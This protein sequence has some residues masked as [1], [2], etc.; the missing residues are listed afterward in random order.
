MTTIS[1]ASPPPPQTDSCLK[2]RGVIDIDHEF[3]AARI[4]LVDTCNHK[5]ISTHFA[6]RK[7]TRITAVDAR[8]TISKE[9]MSSALRLI[10]HYNQVSRVSH[11]NHNI[12]VIVRGP[13]TKSPNVLS[14]LHKIRTAI[15][16]SPKLIKESEFGKIY[17]HAAATQTSFKMEEI[18]L[19][20]IS[21]DEMWFSYL[22]GDEAIMLKKD[23][24]AL[25]L[26]KEA[27]RIL[28]RESTPNPMNEK[29]ITQVYD[30]AKEIIGDWM[31]SPDLSKLKFEHR[32]VVGLGDIH[33][34]SIK[35]QTA[36][37]VSYNE[38]QI[39]TALKGRTGLPDQAISGDAPQM[40]VTNLIF[41]L[42]TMKG[43]GISEVELDQVGF[44]FGLLT[45]RS[46]WV[47]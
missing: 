43:L 11:K 23:F 7:P 28:G 24:G 20:S 35:S 30:Y 27:L 29:E 39:R 8:Q 1:C 4:A 37:D 26:Q 40:A 15:K 36:A 41:I 9:F 22:D 19:W 13:L 34:V 47:H 42:A 10:K 45:D 5:V 44:T 32:K 18:I 46:L 31:G 3:V 38:L 6:E 16:V 21:N 25:S 2:K 17:L 33:G 14:F 12:Q